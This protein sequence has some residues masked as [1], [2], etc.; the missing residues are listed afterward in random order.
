[1]GMGLI[2]ITEFAENGNNTNLFLS[3]FFFCP[4]AH[5]LQDVAAQSFRKA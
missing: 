5:F 4:C 3:D 2:A 1:M